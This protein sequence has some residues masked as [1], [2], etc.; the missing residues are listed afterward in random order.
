M[1]G[2][3]NAPS[4][5]RQKQKKK[6]NKEKSVTSVKRE[7]DTLCECNNRENFDD[8]HKKC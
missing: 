5:H 1:T 7:R 2:L 3:F 4:I 6:K 8:D